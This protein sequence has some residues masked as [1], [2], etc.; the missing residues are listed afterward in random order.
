MP[1]SLLVSLVN[2][3]ISNHRAFPVDFFKYVKPKIEIE[4]GETG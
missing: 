1:A 4:K 2:F 3:S